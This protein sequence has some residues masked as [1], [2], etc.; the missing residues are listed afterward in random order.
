[1]YV[2]IHAFLIPR[3]CCFIDDARTTNELGLEQVGAGIQM[4]PNSVRIMRHLGV[5]PEIAQVSTIIQ[6]LNMRRYSTG[7][8]VGSKDVGTLGPTQYGEQWR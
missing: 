8:L 2:H 6:R 5:L 3:S 1:M 7:E 4:P